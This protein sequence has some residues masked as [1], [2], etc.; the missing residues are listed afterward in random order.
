MW[1]YVRLRSNQSPMA[2]IL[3]DC[4]NKANLQLV[5]YHLSENHVECATVRSESEAR[6]FN[7]DN[8]TA[9]QISRDAV[10]GPHAILAYDKA[11]STVYLIDSVK[12]L[13]V[14]SAVLLC[15]VTELLG[16]QVSVGRGVR[17]ERMGEVEPNTPNQRP[18]HEVAMR[19]SR[20]RFVPRRNE[21][22][23]CN[24]EPWKNP[25]TPSALECGGLLNRRF[26]L[27][28]H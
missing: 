7:L 13:V 1:N 16:A 18:N 28:K 20:G 19:D 3:S 6:A 11:N 15:V 2:S 27:G 8:N 4:T 22:A 17:E 9:S 10:R 5:I 14:A 24:D 23:C 21:D 26:R 12:D 25:P